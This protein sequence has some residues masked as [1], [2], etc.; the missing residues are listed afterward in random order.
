[1]TRDAE[2]FQDNES[3]LKP[4][5]AVYADILE[6]C[7]AVW[8]TFMYSNGKPRSSAKTFLISL[9]KP[10][11]TSFGDILK[12]FERDLREF[13][14]RALHSDRK[15]ARQHYADTRNFQREVRGFM[16]KTTSTT[17]TYIAPLGKA[18]LTSKTQRQIMEQDAREFRQLEA[19][20]EEQHRKEKHLRDSGMIPLLIVLDGN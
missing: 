15:E 1:L 16:Q 14:E 13:E 4:L 20:R 3:V 10:Y 11:E 9:R 6:F 7:S 18:V 8:R 2:I 12:R 5:V 19:I 17:L